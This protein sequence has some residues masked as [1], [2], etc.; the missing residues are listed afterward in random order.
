MFS[1]VFF[2]CFVFLWPIF[3]CSA[4]AGLRFCSFGCRPRGHCLLVSVAVLLLVRWFCGLRLAVFFFG[5]PYFFNKIVVMEHSLTKEMLK[6][7]VCM[8]NLALGPHGAA[9]K[10]RFKGFCY[11]CLLFSFC[12]LT[13]K[14]LFSRFRALGFSLLSFRNFIFDGFLFVDLRIARLSFGGS[15]R[16]LFSA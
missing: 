8:K 2:L 15:C 1:F 13:H 16:F 12:F 3:S 9:S 4:L 14:L 11:C 5:P 6:K 10:P 7:S